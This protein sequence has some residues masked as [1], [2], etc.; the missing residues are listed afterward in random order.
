MT[1]AEPGVKPFQTWREIAMARAVTLSSPHRNTR[2][3][4]PLELLMRRGWTVTIR[5]MLF[6]SGSVLGPALVGQALRDMAAELLQGVPQ[7][8]LERPRVADSAER[9]LEQAFPRGLSL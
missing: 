2:Y 9:L 1:P 5:E 3:I 7:A 4:P 8:A 6:F